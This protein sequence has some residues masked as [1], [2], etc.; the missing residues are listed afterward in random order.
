MEGGLNWE[1]EIDM[2]TLWILHII[3]ENLLYSSRNC[4]LWS[5]KWEGNPPKEGMYM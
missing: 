2:Y 5:P 3:N 4:A 1:I